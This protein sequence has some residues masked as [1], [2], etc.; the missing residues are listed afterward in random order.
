MFA[1]GSEMVLKAAA[2]SAD[3]FLVDDLTA[4]LAYVLSC[5]HVH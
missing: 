1:V 4:V 5:C 3:S 2:P